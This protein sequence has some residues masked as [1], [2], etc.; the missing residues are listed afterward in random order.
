MQRPPEIN[1]AIQLESLKQQ[2][3][4]VMLQSAANLLNQAHSKGASVLDVDRLYGVVIECHEK[5]IAFLSDKRAE[6][7]KPKIELA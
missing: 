2:I 6:A 3:L 5:A 4:G 7:R 1:E